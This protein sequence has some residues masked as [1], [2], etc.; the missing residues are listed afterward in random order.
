MSNKSQHQIDAAEKQ[1]YELQKVVGYD[2]REFT[3]QIIVQKYQEGKETDENEIYVPIYQREFTWDKRR[4]STFIESVIMGLP[5]P[6]V[7]VAE[8]NDGRLEIVD[9]SQRIR[10]LHAFLNNKLVLSNL[11]KLFH[12]NNFKFEDLPK[13]RQRKVG[14]IPMRMIV[15]SEN[16]TDE[17][18]KDMFE[19]INR[20]S[21]LLLPMEKRKG[22]YIGP[23][24]NF[25]YE[26]CSPNELFRELAPI[27]K[28]FEKRQEREELILRYFA[29]SD[30]NHENYIKKYTK[31]TGITKFL[32]D[33]LEDKNKELDAMPSE[34]KRNVLESYKKEFDTMLN[35][36]QKHFPLGFRKAVNPQTSRRYFEALSVGITRALRINPKIVLPPKAINAILKSNQFKKYLNQSSNHK[37]IIQQRRI[38][39]IAKSLLNKS[40][41]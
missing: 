9:G 35:F 37:S 36:V 41:K 32:D 6:L 15:L 27:D 3:I 31:K 4:Q 23:F 11:E 1:I 38:D 24:N 13:T 22:I 20:G 18:K 19:R 17:V 12:L 8:N 14:N 26:V 34:D 21:D 7:F 2:T 5:I 29:F 33:F 16:A 10:T 25:I 40:I 39:Y 30:I 28:F